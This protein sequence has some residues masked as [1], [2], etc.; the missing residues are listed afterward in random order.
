MKLK[1]GDSCDLPLS[2]VTGFRNER[3]IRS[4]SIVSRLLMKEEKGEWGG[5]EVKIQQVL[6]S[7]LVDYTC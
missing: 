7:I 5:L 1:G 4:V 2:F 6:V 3:A